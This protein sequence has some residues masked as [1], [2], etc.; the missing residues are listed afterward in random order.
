MRAP[1][2]DMLQIYWKPARGG[3]NVPNARGGGTRPESCPSKTW[4]L[5]PQIGGFLKDLCRK[6]SISGAL[7]NSKFHPPLI[8]GDLIP[9]IPPI[10]AKRHV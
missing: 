7:G 3:Q 6:G 10:V 4:T 1:E 5:T 8:F 2:S 9:P